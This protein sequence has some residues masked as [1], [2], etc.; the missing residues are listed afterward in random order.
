[1]RN[2]L[3]IILIVALIS[4]VLLSSASASPEVSISDGRITEIGSTTT[5]N[6]TLSE[7][8]NGLSGFNITISLS[9]TSIAEIISVEF[10]DWAAIKKNSSLP[11]DSVWLKA[12]DLNCQ[13]DNG[14]ANVSL[15][16]LTVRADSHGNTSILI[17]AIS[18]DDDNGDMI[19]PQTHMGRL[20]VIKEKQ[21]PTSDPNGPYTGI[22]GVPITFN[23]SAS[24]DPD[25]SIVTYAWDF[26]DENT[27]SGVNPV[28]IYTHNGTYTLN[29]IVTDDDGATDTASTTAVIANKVDITGNETVSIGSIIMDVNDTIIVPVTFANA[30]DIG[31]ITLELVYD[32]GIVTVQDISTN[33]DIPS[34]TVTY[35]IDDGTAVIEL[36]NHDNITLTTATPLIDIAFQ[37][38]EN[39]GTTALE[40]QNVELTDDTGSHA[41]FAITNGSITVCVKGDFNNNN[42]VDIGD[43]AKV[44]FMVVGKVSEDPRADFNDNERV[45]VGDAAKIS[46]YLAGKVDGL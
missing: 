9:N 41:P 36:T 13:I 29:L 33:A 37:A 1:M 8:A 20:E 30:T 6:I 5:L 44:A 18:M 17:D 45:D 43:A 38:G 40:L 39:T 24:S 21:P 7:A 2:R 3:I 31:Q 32:P 11:G 16:T 26:G 10:P 46:F 35:T 28:H 25:G 19:S 34:S 4:S 14:A 27:G 23:G 22:E 42:R 15:A 12:A